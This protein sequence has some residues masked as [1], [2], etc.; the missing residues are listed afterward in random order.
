MTVRISKTAKDG[1][2]GLLPGE[3]EDGVAELGELAG[4]GR[5]K[6]L[7]PI[8]PPGGLSK[9][10]GQITQA[11]ERGGI[12]GFIG[13]GAGQAFTDRRDGGIQLPFAPFAQNH[14]QHLPNVVERDEVIPAVTQVM[15]DFGEAPVLQFLEA[16]ADVGARDAEQFRDLIGR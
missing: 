9:Q 11:L 13:S 8:A 15:D 12:G 4:G 5:R 6:A 14:E 7:C 3:F 1:R 2:P 10:L 16:R